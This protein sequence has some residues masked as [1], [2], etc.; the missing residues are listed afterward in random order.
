[1]RA[2][3]GGLAVALVVVLLSGCGGGEGG[4]AAGSSRPA[5][6]QDLR[7]TLEG[8]F[9][10][11]N[12]ALAMAQQEGYFADAGLFVDVAKP[13]SPVRPIPYVVTGTADLGISHLPEVALARQR[14]API[15]AVGSL[16]SRPTAAMIWLRRSGIDGLADLAGRTIA[17][18]GLSYQEDFLASALNRAGLSLADVDVERVGYGLLPALVSGRADAVLG[19]GNLEGAWLES[20]GLEPVLVPART[21]GIP[22]YDELVIVARRDF[23]ESHSP[24][25]EEFMSALS[26]GAAAAGANPGSAREAIE[27]S[28]APAPQTGGRELEAEIAATLPL[29]SAGGRIDSERAEALTEW[30]H[31]EGML[32][33]AL[34]AFELLGGE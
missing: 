1:M 21:L 33:R 34:P 31:G 13:L 11:A 14:G 6:P 29:L 3:R 5:E 17:I 25:I 15:V 19:T 26:R 27:Q 9:G 12:V 28:V 2:S 4:E 7:V 20:R 16:V 8:Y 22:R 30:M 32:G 24:A 18:P 10:P 23:A